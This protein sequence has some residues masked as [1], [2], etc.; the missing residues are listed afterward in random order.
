MA[1]ILSVIQRKNPERDFEILKQIGSG[2]YGEVYKAREVKTGEL[3]ALKIIKIE[4]GE[5]FNII[6][7]EIAI[8]A[9]CK[10]PNIVGYHGSYLRRDRLWIAMEYCG[11]G[12]LQDIYHVTNSGLNELQIAFVCREILKGLQYLHERSKMHRDIKGANILLTDDGDVKLADFGIAAQLT[13]TMQLKRK[14]FIGT[15]YWMAPEVAAVEKKGGYNQQCDIWA[16]G[17][18]AIELAET[19]PPMFDLHPMRAL[20]LMTKRNF[21]PPSLQHRNKWSENFHEFLRAALQRDPKRRPPASELLKQTFVNR[22]ALCAQLMLPLIKVLEAPPKT[23]RTPVLDYE[24]EEEGERPPEG[25][26]KNLR[27]ISSVKN[28]QKID[29]QRS[30]AEMREFHLPAPMKAEPPKEP[31]PAWMQCVADPNYKPRI[32]RISAVPMADDP[33]YQDPDLQQQAQSPASPVGPSLPPATP[34][35]KGHA[36]PL[37]PRHSQRGHR[38]HN[39]AH[40]PDEPPSD[41]PLYTNVEQNPPV[42]PRQSRA[43]PQP[44]VPP[45]PPRQ[46]TTDN[47]P[48]HR[49]RQKKISED[50]KAYFSKIFNGCPLHLNCASA[51]VNPVSKLQY[52]ILGA[53]EGLFSLLV[54]NNPDPVMEQVSSRSC[55]WLRVVESSL[56]WLSGSGR[57]LFMTNLIL[58]FQSES[59]RASL[60]PRNK[61]H[62]AKIPDSKGCYKCCISRNPFSDQRYLIALVPKGVLLMQWYQPK[63]A[64]M[65]V[66]LFECPI[67]EPMTMIEAFVQE[68]EEY[69]IVCYG[70]KEA[71]DGSV[72]FDTMNLNSQAS[73]FTD[74]PEGKELPV[75]TLQQLERDTIFIGIDRYAKF[76]DRNGILKSSSVQANQIVFERKSDHMVYLSNCVLSFHK[77]GMQGK[78]LATQQVTAE[79]ADGSKIFH[80]LG[81]HGTIIIETRP[82]NDPAAPS[83]IYIL[84]SEDSPPQS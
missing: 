60:Q 68:S 38:G 77:H 27:R 65:H 72:L 5:D 76:V 61:Q 80:L 44:S 66:M 2:T 64:F 29:R 52:I 79:V 30:E 47:G 56:I 62:T 58:L 16:V 13:Q 35:P 34:S 43:F 10:Y 37:P 82:A 36:P 6:Q 19:Q 7:Q 81:S 49:P 9:D 73:W 24:E 57:F 42:P 75:L 83:N 17:I 21:K 22:P 4:P 74:K 25:K 31:I 51:W 8:L 71:P 59:V 33:E 26:R 53:D 70:V 12:S 69:P 1:E 3:V 63:H 84:V 41:G 50:R 20:Y 11:G 40:T 23:P 18:T 54:T 28:Q 46:R 15:P 39:R 32:E 14:S 45:I 67:P 48:A 78:S 55:H